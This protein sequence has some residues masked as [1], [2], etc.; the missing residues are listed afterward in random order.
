LTTEFKVNAWVKSLQVE[1]ISMHAV[2][3]YISYFEKDTVTE[4]QTG[5][6][7]KEKGPR[8]VEIARNG[9]F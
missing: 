3:L 7:T 6:R 9:E 2:S 4:A 5:E 1:N 8:N